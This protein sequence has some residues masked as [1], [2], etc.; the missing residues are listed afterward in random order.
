MK[1][2][3]YLGLLAVFLFLF[4]ITGCKLEH[5]W[6]EW[7]VT[8]EATCFASGEKTRKCPYCGE[9]EKI[10]ISQEAAHLFV[11]YV[12]NNE[13]D[14]T[15]NKTATAVCEYGCGTTHTIV[16]EAAKSHT[17]ELAVTVD[18]TCEEIGYEEYVC[19]CGDSYQ[20]VLSATGHTYEEKVTVAV[21]CTTDGLLT[22][23]CSCG[24]FYTQTVK[25]KGHAYELSA[26]N[27]A[28]CTEDGS[29]V[30]ECSCGDSYEETL[31]ANGHNYNVVSE[32]EA[33][34]EEDGKEVY[35]CSCGDSYENVLEATGHAYGQ[36]G[37]AELSCTQNEVS[38]YECNNCGDTY[39]VI[40]EHA[41]GHNVPT[42][43]YVCEEALSD[44]SYEQN[45]EGLCTVCEEVQ[46]KTETVTKHNYTTSVIKTEA[47]CT[48][49][50]VKTYSC[51]CGATEDRDYE[52][53]GA[54]V[55]VADTEAATVSE[56]ST[57]TY[58]CS[59]NCGETKSEIIIASTTGTV[60]KENLAENGVALQNASLKLDADTL[61]GLDSDEDVSLTAESYDVDNLPGDLTKEE[62]EA[63]VEALG[64]TVNENTKI[65]NFGL[66][67]GETPVSNFNGKITVTV[68]YELAP[69]EDPD[70]IA[71]VY[72]NDEGGIEVF[73][74]VYANGYATFETD[75]FSYYTVTRLTPAERC[76]AYGH[77][78]TDIVK[79]A[80]C[81]EAG[82]T[83]SV[84]QRC[85]ESKTT[86]VVSA[87]GH[88][89]SDV[90][91]PATCVK[92]GK[93]EHSCTN[94]GCN[95]K[96]T[97]IIAA[98]GHALELDEELSVEA[99]CTEAGKSV[100]SCANDNCAYHVE[101]VI[102]A[103]GHN[104][105]AQEGTATC[106]ENGVVE[107]IC[108]HCDNSY[109][110]VQA[111]IGHKW[112]VLEKV[113]ATATE[114]GYVLYECKNCEEQ[115]TEILPKTEGSDLDIV[116]DA[117]A[118]LFEQNMTLVLNDVYLYVEM[119]GASV[120]GEIDPFDPYTEEL[121]EE[122]Y[123]TLDENGN[124]VGSGTIV[125]D[126][127]QSA[128]SVEKSTVKFYFVDNKFYGN[129]ITTVDGKV[130]Q[131]FML[132]GDIVALVSSQTGEI[133]TEMIEALLA[134]ANAWYNDS[135][136]E[137]AD[138]IVDTNSDAVNA[139]L[140]K[141]VEKVLILEDTEEGKTI[142]LN[143]LALQNLVDF[144]YNNTLY[145]VLAEVTGTAV[146]ENVDLIFDFNVGKLI[147]FVESKG[148]V[149][150]E[151]MAS[152]DDLVV[153]MAEMGMVPED[154]DSVNTLVQIMTGSEEEVD[155]LAMITSDE[156]KAVSVGD[157]IMMLIAGKNNNEGY[158]DEETEDLPKVY[159]E[160]ES[161]EFTIDNIKAQ[162]IETIESLKDVKLFDMLAAN[163][164]M[165]AE[166]LK[167]MVDQILAL[168]NDSFGASALL[169]S[170]NNVV[171]ATINVNVDLGPIALEGAI[172][173][174]SNYVPVKPNTDV[175]EEVSDLQDAIDLY[176]NIEVFI[177]YMANDWCEFDL[178]Y[179]EETGELE[180]LVVTRIYNK[181]NGI[182]LD[183]EVYTINAED[184]KNYNQMYTSNECSDWLEI[185]FG[186]NA[187]VE[188]YSSK[189]GISADGVIDSTSITPILQETYNDNYYLYVYYN[190][191]TGDFTD[192]A[193]ASHNYEFNEELS[194]EPA[195]CTDKG[196]R[197]LECTKC[198][199][200]YY[201]YYTMGHNFEKSGY[202]LLG[203]SC[204]DGVNII[205]SCIRCDATDID[206]VYYHINVEES[207]D[208]TN[209]G[210][211][212]DGNFI[213][214]GCACG[215]NRKYYV[216]SKCEFYTEEL[217][218]SDNFEYLRLYT[219][220]V[221]NPEQC[222]FKYAVKSTIQ[223]K[224]ANCYIFAT[225]TYYLGVSDVEYNEETGEYT[226]V[227]AQKE[228][229]YTY[230]TYYV[231]HDF[232]RNVI[233]DDDSCYHIVEA[234]ACGET[235]TNIYTKENGL[236]IK[237]ETYNSNT[238][239]GY[240]RY[241]L[242]EYMYVEGHQFTTLI[243]TTTQYE[244]QK[245]YWYQYEY[246][247]YFTSA[248][249][250]VVKTYSN[251]DGAYEVSEEIACRY[252]EVYTETEH[253]C[254]QSTYRYIECVFCG[255]KSE[256]KYQEW[257]PQGHKWQLAY[258]QD[259]YVCTVCGLE[260]A[261]G[262]TG[263][264]VL[265]DCTT[266]DSDVYTVGYYVGKEELQYL[267]V[268]SL[269]VE[270]DEEPV[271]LEGVEF[272]FAEEGRYVSFSKT[273]VE[274]LAAAMSYEAG[275]Y[276][277]RINFVPVDYTSELEYAITFE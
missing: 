127:Y 75:H 165:T 208:L 143:V 113:P 50:G 133:P 28:T 232:E 229:T 193:T 83:L 173:L 105:E 215:E 265:E 225:V 81:T 70:S 80:T 51:A 179:N 19:D 103:H 205:Y 210:S 259:G 255:T 129:Q 183:Y 196:K 95:Y 178:V 98:V 150:E 248:P 250:I 163:M 11:T 220:A 181:Y 30:Y 227:G 49:P 20:K 273:Q 42:W 57:V 269:V 214:S 174:D 145:D 211:V 64:G 233:Q 32:V 72:I 38:Y 91:T 107:Y 272:T 44:C 203:E 59:N 33:T 63:A 4:V 46:T 257:A 230:N 5:S 94:Q 164:D 202:E 218:Y 184:I 170:N 56:T 167:E 212:C 48:I 110:T 260:N 58:Y 100:L 263:A 114:A 161:D 190:P 221:T 234:C 137:V 189:Y 176:N 166:E 84:C 156:V 177:G 242:L 162:V 74:A 18:P 62:V 144:L 2:I 261:N 276:N 115:H 151:V 14:C 7:E 45:Y 206:T 186:V 238:S 120:G 55:W 201:Y 253:P 82:Y 217:Y 267:I 78:M 1:K 67:Q 111:A 159:S 139:M 68:P 52:N 146:L 87:K 17:H 9:V 246:V 154:A 191:L 136:K 266:E 112:L 251:V 102:P 224:S 198:D 236:T 88:A 96:Y 228:I 247:Y 79:E 85:G 130:T 76:K 194:Y 77:V 3:K 31:K 15:V 122:L 207:Y 60:A 24:N 66:T 171:K 93:V 219:C 172:I 13:K 231:S 204:K 26:T 104:Y 35:E 90:T 34:C 168:L 245:E 126:V 125:A 39:D 36:V 216:E 268:V 54:H 169:D 153:L 249:C 121:I 239:T 47:T 131:D 160:E 37:Y 148:F 89:V 197:Y 180:T 41:K 108:E 241:S 22:Y 187:Y 134:M 222:T 73:P 275:T 199:D 118:S 12:N 223:S 106:L 262:A 101:K 86:N 185:G 135:F 252:K 271:V 149:L 21:N 264:I 123:L 65:Y 157:F 99:T 92:N 23:E 138:K 142:T 61:S 116:K 132:Y 27:E 195:G 71:I 16:V 243:K 270:E 119:V 237:H 10:E 188:R 147:D 8:R 141:V 43:A 209:Y 213:I 258:D 128:T 140:E 226:V 158:G 155:I 175:K 235:I 274:E 25:A 109:S 29:N 53:A 152:L 256:E 277:I 117:L 69:G 200:Y 244:G 254:T 182:I 240:S 6:S 40:G 97:T 192:G 124:L